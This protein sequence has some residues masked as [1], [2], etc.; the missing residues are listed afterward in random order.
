[1]PLFPC[2]RQSQLVCPARRDVL[3]AT[4][5]AESERTL[6][7]KVTIVR[8]QEA[9]WVKVPLPVAITRGEHKTGS[10]Q[11]VIMVPSGVALRSAVH[12]IVCELYLTLPGEQR[13]AC[14]RK[15]FK[16]GETVNDRS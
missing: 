10:L 3:A 15:S 4:E 6:S 14:A 11:Q 12:A 5:G 9:D 8:R 13:Q 16:R 1:M 2:L 7:L